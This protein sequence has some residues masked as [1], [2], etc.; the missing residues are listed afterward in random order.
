MKRWGLLGKRIEIN[1]LKTI[2]SIIIAAI[3]IHNWLLTENMTVQRRMVYKSE[4]SS[5]VAL[6]PDLPEDPT[7]MRDI[8]KDYFLEEG[9]RH[10]QYNEVLC[11][12][13]K[14]L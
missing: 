3:A 7:I 8:L 10:W 13:R 12:R 1:S 4:V 6:V 14:D 9:N 11:G 5:G 2:D